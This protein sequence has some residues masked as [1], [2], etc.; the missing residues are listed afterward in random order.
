MLIAVAHV[1]QNSHALRT[2]DMLNIATG[3][4]SGDYASDESDM[5][6]EGIET[7]CEANID[8]VNTRRLGVRLSH[9][10]N[11]VVDQMAFDCTVKGGTNYWFVQSRGGSG[12][13]GGSCTANLSVC[14]ESTNVHKHK[15][16]SVLGSDRNRSTTSTTSTNPDI[17]WLENS[18]L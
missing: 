5:M 3:K 6:R 1:D 14:P 8:R 7:F 4:R 16:I 17:D 12:G 11:R 2:S 18:H 10:R 13:S 9:F 15:E